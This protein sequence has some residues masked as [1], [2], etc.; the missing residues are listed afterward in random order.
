MHTVSQLNLEVCQQA[1]LVPEQHRLLLQT[2]CKASSRINDAY[3]KRQ[4][5][6]NMRH[7]CDIRRRFYPIPTK[8]R[9]KRVTSGGQFVRLNTHILIYCYLLHCTEARQQ[10]SDL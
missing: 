5:K 10:W 1:M 3:I 6:V 7:Q 8:N 9:N 4:D 2:Q